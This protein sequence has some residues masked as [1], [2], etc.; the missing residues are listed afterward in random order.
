MHGSFHNVVV[1]IPER[2]ESIVIR[3]GYYAPEH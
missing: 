1:E 3:S 2:V